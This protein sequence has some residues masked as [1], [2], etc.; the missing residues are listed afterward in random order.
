[1]SLTFLSIADGMCGAASSECGPEQSGYWM[2]SAPVSTECVSVT[3][4]GSD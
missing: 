3:E 2:A 1:M 4:M